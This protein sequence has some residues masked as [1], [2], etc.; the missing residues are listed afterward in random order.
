MID[1][2][3][4]NTLNYFLNFMYENATTLTVKIIY[5]K[6]N[7]KARKIAYRTSHDKYCRDIRDTGSAVSQGSGRCLTADEC[8]MYWNGF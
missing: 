6:E 5:S 7:R 2:S 1:S 8:L 3:G 4:R